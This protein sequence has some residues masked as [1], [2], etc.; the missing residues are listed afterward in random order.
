MKPSVRQLEI[1]IAIARTGSVSRCAEQLL[2]TQS[3]AS[4]ALG[5]L[6]RLLGG[7]LF[8]RPG[9][10][11]VL[12]DRGRFLLPRAGEILDRMEEL[13]ELFRGESSGPI[14]GDLKIAASSTVGNYIIPGIM[15]SFVERNPHVKM[16]LEV[17]NSAQVVERVI[18]YA[19]DIGFVE[20]MIHDPD[21]TALPWMEDRL[22]IFSNPAHPLAKRKK[23]T[24]SDLEKTSWILRERG[25][26]TREI[27]E[28]AAPGIMNR[29]QVILE[30]GN[31]EAIKE[32]VERSFSVSCIS[33]IAIDRDLANGRFKQI[34]VPFLN[35]ERNF[36]LIMHREK[37]RSRVV[38]EF[39]KATE[40]SQGKIK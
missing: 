13:E 16:S 5:E 36:Y 14:Q 6:E 38:E 22:I 34:P 28:N 37:Y 9:K 33:R 2:I 32:A 4:M 23:I 7:P 11:L 12:N 17:L 26:G 39:L 30:L 20:G 1:F 35:L 19:V 25:S 27:F 10:R 3:A 31:S 40:E 15:G 18:D 21:L 8:D 29:M 24:E